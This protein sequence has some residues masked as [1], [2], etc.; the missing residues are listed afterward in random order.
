MFGLGKLNLIAKCYSFKT[1]FG[2]GSHVEA[3]REVCFLPVVKL[4][5]VNAQK[6]PPEILKDY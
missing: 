4:N 2:A 3:E 6:I 1:G 5:F